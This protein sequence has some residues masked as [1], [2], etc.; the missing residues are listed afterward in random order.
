[1]IPEKETNTLYLAHC[2]PQKQPVFYCRFLKVLDT[3]GITPNLLPYTKDIWAVD[4]MPVQISENKFVQFTYDPDYLQGEEWQAT[5]TDANAVCEAI[6][7]QTTKTDIKVDGGNVIRT[8]DKVIMCDKVFYENPS[9]S[10]KSLIHELEKLFE[11]DK[12]IFIPWHDDDFTGHADGMIRFIDNDT[13]LVNDLTYEEKGFKRSLCSTLKKAHLDFVELPYSPPHDPAGISANGLYINYLQMQQAVMVPTFRSREDDKAIKL[14]EQVF[15][16]H[17]IA[18]LDA[19][20]VAR[21]GGV[22]NCISWN[23]R[24]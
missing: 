12:L 5:I 16:G 10:K 6:E 22:L 17:T 1:M 4:Y 11:V 19:C 24:A 14:L 2:L 9:F 20:D 8:A 3:C 21:E 15:K 23:I 13:V 7:L 18:H